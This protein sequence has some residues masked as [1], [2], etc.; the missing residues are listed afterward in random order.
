MPFNL[1]DLSLR[2]YLFFLLL[3]CCCS[4]LILAQTDKIT[5]DLPITYNINRWTT[6]DNLPQNSV[7]A[8]L[9]A[10]DGFIWIG[11]YGGLVRFDGL[12]FHRTNSKTLDYERV[13]NI[14]EDSKQNI[15]VGTENN[16]VFKYNKD[17]LI[18]FSTSN[19]LPANGISGIAEGANGEIIVLVQE[20]GLVVIKEDSIIRVSE[21]ELNGKM[22]LQV[23][24]DENNIAW[25]S[26]S[27]GVYSFTIETGILKW[28]ADS[29]PPND[30]FGISLS[31]ENELYYMNRTAIYKV[32]R[33]SYSLEKRYSISEPILAKQFL[34][35]DSIT[36]YFGVQ[37]KGFY[38]L[39][40]GNKQLVAKE[41]AE[42]RGNVSAIYYKNKEEIWLGFNGGGLIKLSLNDVKYIKG[43]LASEI[44]L[45][46]HKDAAQ[47]LWVGTN[48]GPLYKRDK[49]GETII[50]KKGD[51][52]PDFDVWSI[53]S[54]G[55]GKIWVGTFGFGVFEL[56]QSKSNTF[57]AL[58]MDGIKNHTI[59]AMKYDTSK[60]RLLIGTDLGG[61]Y[62]LKD[63]LWAN[64]ITFEEVGSRITKIEFSPKNEPYFA[65]LNNGYFVFSE[66]NLINFSKQNGL[67]SNNIRE[68]FF[69][70]NGQLWIGTYD[71]GLVVKKGDTFK[72]LTTEEGLKENLISSIN[73]DNQD[74][75]WLSGNNGIYK[76]G[77]KEIQEVFD[78]KQ[79]RVYPQTFNKNRGMNISETNGGFQQSSILDSNQQLYYPTMQG[80]AVL[81]PD[82]IKN[83]PLIN[84]VEIT[85]L[86]FKDSSILSPQKVMLDKDIRDLSFHFTSPYFLS[87]ELIEF[88]YWLEGYDKSWRSAGNNR[89][90][91]YTQLPH[92][93]FTFKV[94]AKNNQG[95]VGNDVAFSTITIASFFYETTWFKVFCVVVFLS[96]LVFVFIRK[97]QLAKKR[98]LSLMREVDHRTAE[99]KNE[100]EQTELALKR[101]AI[102]SK[103]LEK[104]NKAKTIFFSNVSHELKTP[105]TLIKGPVDSILQN[106]KEELNSSIQEDLGFIQK[107]SMRLTKL[108]NQLLDIARSEEGKLK[109][110]VKPFDCI[111]LIEQIVMHHRQWIDQK[112]IKVVIEKDNNSIVGKSDPDLLE[113]IIDN[114]FSNALKF[115]PQNGHISIQLILK[116]QTL[117][118]TVKDSGEGINVTDLNHIFDRFYK[119]K[120]ATT[121]N[122][123][124]SGIGLSLSKQ[125]AKI[126]GGDLTV[127]NCA[128]AGACFQLVIPF[129]AA[130]DELIKSVSITK[131]VVS[132]N[133]PIQK[134]PFQQREQLPLL[135]LVDDHA[136]I[137]KF[138]RKNLE[139]DFQII[140]A[141]NGAEGFELAKQFIPD[142]IVSDIM[143]P[144]VD[145]VELLEKLKNDK[146]TNFIGVIMLTAKGADATKIEAWQKGADAYLPKPFNSKEL[147]AIINSILANRRTL[148]NHFLQTTNVIDETFK[149]SKSDFEIKFEHLINQNIPDPDFKWSDHLSV[150]AMSQSTFQRAVK[151]KYATTPQNYLRKRRLEVAKEILIKQEVSI[152][153]VAYASGFNSL[154][155]FSKQFKS[156]YNCSPSE[157]IA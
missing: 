28:V 112:Q 60:D 94:R 41:M 8:I 72:N 83:D 70:K 114:L 151:E 40:N 144:Q 127:E 23:I 148:R 19:G 32:N 118:I 98:E 5:Q 22:A 26:S 110:V 45:A 79:R 30:D 1:F 69:D 67:P 25:I 78:K 27:E 150:F 13:I 21:Q 38:C 4:K 73:I 106:Y 53:A 15:W 93:D 138:I 59:L 36:F 113:K 147:T 11:T 143:M 97:Q 130:V 33:K 20:R 74:N 58:N 92:G 89:F 71:K 157:M 16:G 80:L 91:N 86:T 139:T 81:E 42:I 39:I 149:A 43:H 9:Q 101:L 103:E 29:K 142:L 140:E 122:K 136:D 116:E 119:S 145:G 115:T 108:I 129:K 63:T 64:L 2:S 35:I 125:F 133:I 107:H 109:K 57:K 46:I 14:F 37:K 117:S 12:R 44:I 124:G 84:F 48:G 54:D 17:E 65:T 34:A 104:A 126:L 24:V 134:K 153:E 121:Q 141:E 52:G 66:G 50:Y 56:D 99:L 135:L 131:E 55:R 88:E 132:K 18:H 82:F 146:E 77:K 128:E 75:I 7:N 152:A 3:L 68:L 137:R 51:N 31:S 62:S 120:N 154:S 102:Q 87:P 123:T 95:V 6:Q 10:S 47:N 111:D 105:L 61:I 100:K 90:A 85:E 155:Y 156:F 49:Y 76:I 96:L